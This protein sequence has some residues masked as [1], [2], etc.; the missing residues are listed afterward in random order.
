[1]PPK[2]PSKSWSSGS[3]YVVFETF[4]TVGHA[5]VTS[6]ASEL[7]FAITQESSIDAGGRGHLC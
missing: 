1:M 2:C 6:F 3:C 5:V 4:L 7:R